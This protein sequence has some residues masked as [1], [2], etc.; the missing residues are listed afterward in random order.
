MMEQQFVEYVVKSLVDHP[1]EV[2]IKR[3]ED[4]RGV[5]LELSVAPEDMGRVIG[6]HGSTA[7][8]LRTVLRAL[9]MKNNAH[10]NLKIVDTDKPAADDNNMKV[11]TE[12]GDNN[13]ERTTK[14]TAAT[15]TAGKEDDAELSRAE[16]LRQD[17]DDLKDF[18]I[19]VM[20]DSPDEKLNTNDK[21]QNPLKRFLVI[22]LFPEMFDGVLDSSMMWK[23]RKDGIVDFQ[24]LNLREF[25]LGPRRKVD[26]KP[27]GGGSGMLL[28]IEPLTKALAEAR[29][30]LPGAKVLIMTPTKQIWD[31]AAAQ[32]H[33]DSD[34][35]Y[36]IL[37][38]RYEGF[39]ARVFDL[40]D[41]KI[42]VGRY[43]V[44]GGELPAMI[45]I[46]SIVRLLPG[47]LGGGP[48]ATKL[49]SYSDEAELEYPQYTRPEVYNGV[50][51]PPVLLSGDHAKV[52]DWRRQ[53]EQR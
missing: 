1:D 37:C 23:A 53:H 48:E 45:I 24:F 47:V 10:Y 2:K 17:I 7:L 32:T 40:I 4:D 9:G 8:S 49:E 25:G 28:M 41:E 3:T 38:G 29:R 20:N 21:P 51:V 22:T 30:R 52:R 44:T 33:A 13:E 36:I 26:D 31:Q 14:N 16:K 35:N 42:S 34:D 50:A 11:S 18:D 19:Q 46:D 27:F 12:A 15:E 39:D 43:V 6:R 5:L